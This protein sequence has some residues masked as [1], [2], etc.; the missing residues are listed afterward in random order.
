LTADEILKYANLGYVGINENLEVSSGYDDD[1][2]GA[3]ATFIEE[4]WNSHIDF[5]NSDEKHRLADLMI[6]RWQ[7]YKGAIPLGDDE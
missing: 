3:A 6:E 4:E 1:I 5:L 7:K 2:P